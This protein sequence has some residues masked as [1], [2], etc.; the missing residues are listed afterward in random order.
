MGKIVLVR[1]A[2]KSDD[3]KNK[4]KHISN[5]G[6]WFLAT[7]VVAALVI[8]ISS[9]FRKESVRPAQQGLKGKALGKGPFAKPMTIGRALFSFDGRLSRADYWCKGILPLL[10][11]S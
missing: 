2:F 8:L 1:K 7:F 3:T 5:T 9:L 4:I 10:P 6:A 11:L